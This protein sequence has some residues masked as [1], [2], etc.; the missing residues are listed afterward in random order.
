MITWKLLVI[1]H[2]CFNFSII[3]RISVLIEITKEL[4]VCFCV[5]LTSGFQYGFYFDQPEHFT[6]HMNELQD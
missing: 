4:K 6:K 3:L 5:N 2:R 1:F